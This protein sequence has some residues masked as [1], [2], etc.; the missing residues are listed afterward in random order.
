MVRACKVLLLCEFRPL[1]NWF[2]K[3]SLV[4]FFLNIIWSVKS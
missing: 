2:E 4:G 1:Q 3:T